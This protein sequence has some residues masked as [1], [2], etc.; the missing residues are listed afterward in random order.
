MSFSKMT[1]CWPLS[2]HDRR[3]G[4]PVLLALWLTACGGAA[5]KSAAP[6]GPTDPD[7]GTD[8]AAPDDDGCVDDAEFFARTAAPLLEA[9]CLQCH[10]DGGA[11]GA[12]AYVLR[13][14]DEDGALD[15]NYATLQAV[16][17]TLGSAAV[18][19]KPTGGTS[20]GGG[21]R[22]DRIDGRFAVLHELVARIEAP[23][24]CTHP[25]TPPLVCDDGAVHPGA[26]PLR[27]LTDVQYA[28]LVTDVYGVGLPDGLFP[29]TPL[30]EGFRTAATV[31]GVS[32]S[33][34][35]SILLA[36][37]HVSDTVDLTTALDCA[38]PASDCGRT[39]L[40]DRAE[41]TWRRPLTS[42]EQAILTRFLDAG[43]PAE[44]GVRMGVF[45]ALQ[46]PQALYLD[47][48]VGALATVGPDPAAD[49][50]ALDP[51]AV[52][53]RLAFFV[54]DGP[55]DAALQEAAADGTL[56]T[57]DDV[58][59]HA[60]RLVA[61]PRATAVVAR[62]HQDWLHLHP[63][64][65]QLKDT[66]AFPGFDDDLVEDM[67][68]ETDLFT[69]EVVWM[70]DATFDQL[71]FDTTTWV[72]PELADLYGVAG[73]PDGWSRVALP[74]AE[75]PGVLSRS[76]FLT[77]HAYA[78]ASS[79]VRRGTWVIENLLCEDLV[80]PPGID[81][82]LPELGGDIE[83]VRDKLAVHAADP[84]CRSC[85]DRIDPVGFS[86]EHFD[87][88]GAWRD[89][90]SS[91]IPVDATGSLEDPA[92]DFDGYAEMI[93][94]V[95]SSE[96][97]RGCYA[98]RWFEYAVGRPAGPGDACS[99]DQLATRFEASGGDIRSLLVDITL[100]DAFLYRTASGAD[101]A[102]PP[103]DPADSG[104]DDATE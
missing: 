8:T 36:A 89:S 26:A 54:T 4:G 6:D 39:W 99:L 23:G 50:H 64:R 97:A 84:S 86:F 47:A 68:T 13:P 33:G 93:A 63:L 17:A 41:A 87:G 81:T 28:S 43:L 77:A 42:A 67:F 15:T 73:E 40:L 52:A 38:D 65:D 31:N 101:P 22:F 61:D 45:V 5:P 83:T 32:A 48:R 94:L 53:S 76:A 27:R 90:W 91:G 72:T 95:A 34:A 102:E 11:A 103:A 9:E 70:G 80:P 44:D 75:R 25:G 96:R 20:H 66:E 92:G 2:V 58:S 29:A 74:E 1:S 46:A 69:T 62:F 79:P 18:L 3:G 35:E 37:E 85:H 100:T 24:A 82:T 78:A 60:A 19:D 14:L 56:S 71:M 21:T 49:V 57:R 16:V 104:A 30:G 55:P 59:R 10:V 7:P 51:H 12:T 98:Q 88:I